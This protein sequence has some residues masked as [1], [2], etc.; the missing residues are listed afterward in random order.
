MGAGMVV[1]ERDCLDYEFVIVLIWFICVYLMVYFSFKE[2][3]YYMFLRYLIVGFGVLTVIGF[4]GYFRFLSIINGDFKTVSGEFNGIVSGVNGDQ[5][6]FKIMLGNGYSITYNSRRTDNC[7]GNSISVV[8][9]AADFQRFGGH[10]NYI[11]FG[12]TPDFLSISYLGDGRDPCIFK[13][14]KKQN[15]KN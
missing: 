11:K 12:S 15:V 8:G 10:D 2:F 1:F 6:R 13:I 9:D 4:G 3:K 14:V 7:F 5:Q